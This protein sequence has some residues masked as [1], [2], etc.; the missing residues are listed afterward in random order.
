METR[1]QIPGFDPS[2]FYKLEPKKTSVFKGGIV[3]ESSYK[4]SF[5]RAIPGEGREQIQRALAVLH[6]AL[7]T[8]IRRANPDAVGQLFL[9]HENLFTN[10]VRASRRLPI[11]ELSFD[12]LMDR[13]EEIIQS[14]K[15]SDDDDGAVVLEE[16]TFTLV[17]FRERQIGGLATRHETEMKDHLR[18]SRGYI[19]ILRKC[20]RL[21]K[22]LSQSCLL[23]C[24]VIGEARIKFKASVGAQATARLGGFIRG[25]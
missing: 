3:V 17:T 20:Y 13:V 10:G 23:G 8:I 22:R 24:V 15:N 11:R 25:R 16:C 21:P 2:D 5:V 7:D 12:H 9:E 1:F 4:V 6:A 14:S 19:D 18:L